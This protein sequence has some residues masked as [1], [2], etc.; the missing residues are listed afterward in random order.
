[1]LVAKSERLSVIRLAALVRHTGLLGLDAFSLLVSTASPLIIFQ[2]QVL[3]GE[4][5]EHEF[6]VVLVWLVDS[7]LAHGLVHALCVEL[8]RHNAI[9]VDVPPGLHLDLELLL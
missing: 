1:M 2:M 5:L 8:G 6:R 4:H 7:L 3:L 9:A